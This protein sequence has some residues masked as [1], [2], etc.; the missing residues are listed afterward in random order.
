MSLSWTPT[1]EQ[2]A[3][4][5]A[6]LRQYCGASMQP[7][8]HQTA[9]RM[10]RLAD[11]RMPGIVARE[12][13]PKICQNRLG[14][15]ILR[16]IWE[17][18][19]Q[20][21]DGQLDL[22]EFRCAAHLLTT[23]S[24]QDPERAMIPRP[25]PPALRKQS[26]RLRFGDGANT[27]GDFAE[28]TSSGPSDSLS[29]VSS[30]TAE[31]I[32][33][34][35]EKMDQSGSSSRK[36]VEDAQSRLKELRSHLDLLEV[37]GRALAEKKRVTLT[38]G[39]TSTLE[40]IY[41]EEQAFVRDACGVVEACWIDLGGTPTHATDKAFHSSRNALPEQ[42]TEH[43]LTPWGSIASL[44]LQQLL[45]KAKNETARE[46][47]KVKILEEELQ[48]ARR[49]IQDMAAAGASA[50]SHYN[51]RRSEMQ[52]GNLSARAEL[53]AHEPGRG[54]R[55][56][57]AGDRRKDSNPSL[58]DDWSLE[59]TDTPTAEV[60]TKMNRGKRMEQAAYRFSESTTADHS[61]TADRDS[62][63][64]VPAEWSTAAE[65]ALSVTAARQRSRGPGAGAK[66]SDESTTRPP[67]YRNTT[68]DAA[69]AF[70]AYLR[71]VDGIPNESSL[72]D[73]SYRARPSERRRSHR[74]AAQRDVTMSFGA[75]ED[76][77]CRSGSDYIEVSE[78]AHEDAR[79]LPSRAA[80]GT[81]RFPRTSVERG[82]SNIDNDDNDEWS[83]SA[84]TAVFGYW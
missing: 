67:T 12:A 9:A 81:S 31:Q 60:S 75:S 19:D 26:L 44:N 47:A 27:A 63:A 52:R 68:R 17:V 64:D 21:H 54:A 50:P 78:S 1:Y 70:G 56:L 25:L 42:E 30:P 10:L 72:D 7:G 59:D 40:R 55:R 82:T 18:S 57:D 45:L 24:H 38:S 83:R 43:S 33:T 49:Q 35:P 41:A 22:Q 66:A 39:G 6:L 14:Q 58:I 36:S 13:F 29:L 28:P 32:G 51:N 80:H 5:D 71:D 23:L 2:I 15:S 62:L 84:S 46:R 69:T 74:Q 65:Q 77:N 73:A 3:D 8:R 4:Y 11:L 34:H 53:K 48:I 16:D 37:R 20:D 76:E 79:Q 61:R